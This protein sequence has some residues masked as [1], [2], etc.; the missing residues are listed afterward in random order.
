MNPFNVFQTSGGGSGGGAARELE[1]PDSTTLT[2]TQVSGTII[3]NVGQTAA[4]DIQLPEAFPGANLLFIAGE[5]SIFHVRFV[6]DAAQ[7]ILLSG[8][9][10]GLGKFVGAAQVAVGDHIQLIGFKT[11]P[12]LC[13]WMAIPG[14]GTWA[15]EV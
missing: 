13:S 14:L 10:G 7:S 5:T 1:V 15:L 3:N 4:L 12:T 9:V 8:Q 6:P 11:S 2:I